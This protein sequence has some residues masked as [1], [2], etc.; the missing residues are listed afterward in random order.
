MVSADHACPPGKPHVDY[1][2][3]ENSRNPIGGTEKEWF[4]MKT[5]AEEEKNKHKVSLSSREIKERELLH[6]SLASEVLSP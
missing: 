4:G 1:K 2:V 5:G 3:R 6:L